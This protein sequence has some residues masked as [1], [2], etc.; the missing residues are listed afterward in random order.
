MGTAA[1]HV[2]RAGDTIKLEYGAPQIF[3]LKHVTGKS[4]GDSRFPPYQPRVLYTLVDERKMFLDAE[5]S[6]EFEHALMDLG[7]RPA[8]FIRVTKIKH[9]RGGGHS[10]RVELAEETRLE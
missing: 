8:D 5:E 10:I 7:V 1:M 3:A 6:S 4:L 2:A 9:P